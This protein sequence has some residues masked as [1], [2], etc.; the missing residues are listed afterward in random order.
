[1]VDRAFRNLAGAAFSL[2]GALSTY[3]VLVADAVIFTNAAFEG[4]TSSRR[5]GKGQATDRE[6]SA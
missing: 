6:V 2:Y 1:A 5:A 4:F 3:D